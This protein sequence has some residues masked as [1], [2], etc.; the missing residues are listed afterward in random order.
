MI[1]T[2]LDYVVKNFPAYDDTQLEAL[3]QAALKELSELRMF[4]VGRLYRGTFIYRLPTGE[5]FMLGEAG[6]KYDFLTSSE[7]EAFIDA[8]LAMLSTDSIADSRIRTDLGV[9]A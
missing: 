9:A 3:R 1:E 5:I 2:A 7:A 4:A 6:L 8:V